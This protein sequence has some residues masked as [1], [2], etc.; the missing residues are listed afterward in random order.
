MNK[1]EFEAL[2]KEI[3]KLSSIELNLLQSIIH[4]MLDKRTVLNLSEQE[5]DFIFGLF[6]TTGTVKN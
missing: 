2:K 5:V 6:Q 3:N 4:S 1:Y